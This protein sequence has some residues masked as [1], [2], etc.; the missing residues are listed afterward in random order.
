MQKRSQGLARPY[1]LATRKS[2]LIR[3]TCLLV[4][5]LRLVLGGSTRQLTTISGTDR[6]LHRQIASKHNFLDYNHFSATLAWQLA[7][8]RLFLRDPLL[9]EPSLRKQRVNARTQPVCLDAPC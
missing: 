3:L 8:T 9:V 4:L 5:A 6:G 7:A 1:D 2:R